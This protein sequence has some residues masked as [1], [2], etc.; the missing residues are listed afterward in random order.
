MKEFSSAACIRTREAF[1][2]V[3]LV[4]FGDFSAREGSTELE[5]QHRLCK[6]VL[7]VRYTLQT[8]HNS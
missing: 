7:Y 5:I 8:V 1:D 2:E 3:R 6:H 4:N